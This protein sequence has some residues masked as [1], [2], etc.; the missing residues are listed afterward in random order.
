[1]NNKKPAY[2]GFLFDK[3]NLD[4]VKYNNYLIVHWSR[5]MSVPPSD[6][7]RPNACITCKFRDAL[8]S[9]IICLSYDKCRAIPKVNTH[10]PYL[11]D[12][13]EYRLCRDIRKNESFC[14]YHKP[15]LFTRFKNF[16]KG[17]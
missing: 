6:N 3:S 15:T 8:S 14:M 13:S 16:I 4:I 17:L 10:D 1:M 5:H 9:D 2:A 11:G 12:V 7:N